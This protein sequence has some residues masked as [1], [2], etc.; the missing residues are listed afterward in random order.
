MKAACSWS[1]GKD[2]A[3]AFWRAVNCGFDIAMIANF[4]TL[5]NGRCCFHGIPVDLISDQAECMNVELLQVDMPE[6]VE[7][8]ENKFRQMLRELKSSG[9]EAMI[10][11]DIYLDEHRDWVEKVCGTENI[12]AILPLWNEKPLDLLTEMNSI[13]L[14][15]TVVSC[16]ERLGEDFVGEKISPNLSDFFEKEQ[17][18]PCGEHGEYHTIVTDAPMFVGKR[19]LLGQTTK[20]LV[21]GFW[22]HWHLDI[23]TWSLVTKNRQV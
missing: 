21:D 1:G 20:I 18:C 15:S 11:G 4:V 19:I 13:G 8:Y 23:K 9:F 12:Q 5:S 2:S 16:L 6:T 7:G 10:F 14:Q 17:I 22:K 3:L